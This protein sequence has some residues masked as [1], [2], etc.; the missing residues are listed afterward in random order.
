MSK[1]WNNIAGMS[2]K[3][4]S[5]QY[6]RYALE[7]DFENIAYDFIDGISLLNLKCQN[8]H[9]AA[10]LFSSFPLHTRFCSTPLLA[11]T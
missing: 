8:A 1:Y 10:L 9:N 2:E 7:F 6:Y 4:K 11:N 5:V 3:S